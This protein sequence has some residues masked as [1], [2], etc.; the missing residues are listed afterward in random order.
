[1]TSYKNVASGNA[2]VEA[3]I[4]SVD[5]GMSLH[6]PVPVPAG[7]GAG[8][9]DRRGSALHAELSARLDDIEAAIR[10]QRDDGTLGR[11]DAASAIEDLGR[12]RD[13]LPLD[14]G[15]RSTRFLTFLKRIQGVVTRTAELTTAVA[16]AVTAVQSTL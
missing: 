2:Q 5:G 12:A 14:D 3:Q 16:G 8:A 11:E 13:L 4:G 15:A 9:P 1:V 6:D 10:R 7:N